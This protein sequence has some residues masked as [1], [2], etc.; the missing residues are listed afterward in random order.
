ME[1][2][3]IDAI[4]GELGG[5]GV[6]AAATTGLMAFLGVYMVFML[7]ALA[8]VIVTFVF[9]W[10]VFVKAKQPGWAAIIPIYSTYVLTQIVGRPWWFVLAFLLAPIPVVGWLAILAV[11]LILSID[12]AKSFGK[13]IGFGIGLA[14][15]GPVFM[16][17]LAFGDAQY[18]GPSAAEN[19]TKL[20]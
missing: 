15:V 13:D 6:E 20:F 1:A 12:L 10:K 3:E 16:G 8:L 9:Q 5:A 17:M 2:A 14:F 18:I 7:I 19:P 4:M 11:Q